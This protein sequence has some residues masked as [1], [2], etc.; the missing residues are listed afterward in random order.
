M[1]LHW[2]HLGIASKC[3]LESMGNYY[4]Y[5][6]VSGDE[7]CCHV[8]ECNARGGVLYKLFMT[9]TMDGMELLSEAVIG[10]AWL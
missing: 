6:A 2:K 5:S 8:G 1:N 10:R 4:K 9:F 7:G 3:K